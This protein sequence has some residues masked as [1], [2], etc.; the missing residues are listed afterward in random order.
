M[1]A[2]IG[3]LSRFHD[4]LSAVNATVD[5]EHPETPR[6]ELRISVEHAGEFVAADA[7]ESLLGSLDAVIRKAEQQLRKHKEKTT[8]RRHTGAKS[9]REGAEPEES[10]ETEPS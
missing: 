9:P 4:R 5:L 6:V 2:K 10:R 3:K 8:D 1:S 7:S